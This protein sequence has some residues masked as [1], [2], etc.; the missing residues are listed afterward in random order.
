MVWPCCDSWHFR[1]QREGEEEEAVA[2]AAHLQSPR[3]VWWLP[4]PFV[5]CWPWLQETGLPGCAGVGN[6]SSFLKTLAEKKKKSFPLPRLLVL[7][8]CSTGTARS[9]EAF[10]ALA[11]ECEAPGYPQPSPGIWCHHPRHRMVPGTPWRWRCL[12]GFAAH[13]LG[14]MRCLCKSVGRNAD[15]IKKK[16]KGNVCHFQ[17]S[18]LWERDIRRAEMQ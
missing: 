9:R 6:C 17:A 4:A 1:E 5:F 2:R 14:I 13:L 7:L 3:L 18:F 10:P 15:F 8:I 12:A 16:K 11:A